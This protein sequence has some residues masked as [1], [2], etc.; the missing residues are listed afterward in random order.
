M[1][2]ALAPKRSASAAGGSTAR[3][4]PASATS[5]SAC[6]ALRGS[7]AL[8]TRGHA[9]GSSASSLPS[10]AITASGILPLQAPLPNAG[11][12]QAFAVCRTLRSYRSLLQLASSKRPITSHQC[13][14]VCC[15][16]A[17]Y[18]T[19]DTTRAGFNCLLWLTWLGASLNSERQQDSAIMLRCRPNDKL[20]KKRAI[21]QPVC[22]CF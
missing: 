22:G 1:L 6:T 3:R 2:T 11:T 10:A 18:I 17:C 8:C 14:S 7:L 15:S 12:M 19:C 21:Q 4:T 9:A 5:L 13:N 16:D 20:K